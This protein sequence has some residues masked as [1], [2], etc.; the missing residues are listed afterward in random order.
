MLFLYSYG[1]LSIGEENVNI[2]AGELG[3][4]ASQSGE[5]RGQGCCTSQWNSELLGE[6]PD[7]V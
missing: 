2:F 3:F 6:A 5:K 1:V 7:L 4:S